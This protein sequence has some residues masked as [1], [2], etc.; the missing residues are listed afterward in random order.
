MQ[1]S[2]SV[3]KFMQYTEIGHQWRKLV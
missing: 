2:A 3:V 1:I